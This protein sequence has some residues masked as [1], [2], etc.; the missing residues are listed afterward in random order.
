MVDDDD[1]VVDDDDVVVD[2]D[3]SA[4]E[5]FC[6][7]FCGGVQMFCTAANEQWASTAACVVDCAGW[8]LGTEGDTT[9]DTLAC[10]G[11]HLEAA[12]TST[13]FA[14]HCPHAG[15]TGGGVCQ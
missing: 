2:D 3:D 9:G 4:F 13:D 15:P 10:R 12:I 8:A 11:Y 6:P 7:E 1:S 14:T 5:D